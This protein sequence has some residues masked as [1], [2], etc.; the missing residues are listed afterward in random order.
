MADQGPESSTAES[1]KE[2][3]GA[4]DTEQADDAAN[5]PGAASDKKEPAA[6]D[7]WHAMDTWDKDVSS[8]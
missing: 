1:T 2:I 3:M 6:D 8:P 7:A 4:A 5:E